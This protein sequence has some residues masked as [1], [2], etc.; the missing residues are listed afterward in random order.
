MPG[1]AMSVYIVAPMLG[2]IAVL[3]CF[4]WDSLVDGSVTHEPSAWLGY[5]YLGMLVTVALF[6]SP[7][8]DQIQ[9][10]PYRSGL[11]IFSFLVLMVWSAVIMFRKAKQWDEDFYRRRRTHYQN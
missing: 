7:H 6:A 10:H 9:T 3:A 8:L 1:G 4:L 11:I 2:L 5:A